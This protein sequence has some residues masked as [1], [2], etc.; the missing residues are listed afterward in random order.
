MKPF[1]PCYS[2]WAYIYRVKSDNVLLEDV[3]KHS[4]DAVQFLKG[5]ATKAHLPE[6]THMN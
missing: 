3:I 1:P 6:V 2:L 5:R 4:E